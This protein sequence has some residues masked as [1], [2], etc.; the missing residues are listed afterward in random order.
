M[1]NSSNTNPTALPPTTSEGDIEL[2][3]SLADAE[4]AWDRRFFRPGVWAHTLIG[5]IQFTPWN[6]PESKPDEVVENALSLI[7]EEIKDPA[8]LIAGFEVITAFQQ[9]H[10]LIQRARLV[11][12]NSPAVIERMFGIKRLVMATMSI[13]LGWSAESEWCVNPKSA[14]LVR[15]ELKE[16]VSGIIAENCGNSYALWSPQAGV[17]FHNAV[18]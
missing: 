3:P 17:F 12:H 14:L 16:G 5:G 4:I 8:I 18:R 11:G 10:K 7:P 13:N 9:H 15:A 1:A 2:P 6:D